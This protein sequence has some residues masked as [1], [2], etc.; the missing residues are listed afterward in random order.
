MHPFNEL[1]F[2]TRP[3]DKRGYEVFRNEIW[4][5]REVCNSCFSQVRNIGPV[6]ERW[7]GASYM[8][9]NEFYERTDN[10]SQEYTPFDVNRRYGTCFCT[11]C[12]SDCTG[13]HRNTSLEDL[14]PL[15]KNIFQY[16]KRELEHDLDAATFGKEVREL[17]SIRDA[18]GYETEIMAI[19]FARALDDDDANPVAN[20][21]SNAVSAD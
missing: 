17:K 7:M 18:T 16:T 13:D 3:T 10:G 14:I 15:V 6:M 20:S 12:G 8:T 9:L 1:P 21:E 2:A 4:W 5:N 19:G 11:Q